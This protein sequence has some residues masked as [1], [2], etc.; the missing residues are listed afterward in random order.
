MGV[1]LIWVFV[2]DD[3]SLVW[4][5]LVLLLLLVVDIELVGEVVDGVVVVEFV[6]KFWF[7]VVLMDLLMLV[8]DGIVVIWEICTCYFDVWVVVLMVFVECVMVLVVIDVGVIGYVFKDGD[9][10]DLLVVIWVAFRGEFL[11]LDL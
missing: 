3:Y 5:G 2:V 4:R 8:M 1:A 11:L 7:D 9:E 10:V 6:V